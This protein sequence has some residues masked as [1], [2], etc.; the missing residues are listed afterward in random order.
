MDVHFNPDLQSKLSC[1]AVQ[2]GRAVEALVEDGLR[3]IRWT[4]VAAN[5]LTHISHSRTL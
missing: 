2:Q 3:V 1:M 5:D 4:K